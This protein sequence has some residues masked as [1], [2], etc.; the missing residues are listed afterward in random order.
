MQEVAIFYLLHVFIIYRHSDSAPW[1]LMNVFKRFYFS[2]FI[3]V[4]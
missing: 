2:T 1:D 4:L 3:E